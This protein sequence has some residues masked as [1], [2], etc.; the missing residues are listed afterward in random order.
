[1]SKGDCLAKQLANHIDWFKTESKSHKRLYRTLRYLVFSLT[2]ASTAL[3]GFALAQPEYQRP[4]NIA[5]I[6]VTAS[7]GLVTSIEGL[8]KPSELWIH[9]RTIY[10]SLMDLQRELQFHGSG[11]PEPGFADDVFD[12]MQIVLGSARDRWSRQIAGKTAIAPGHSGNA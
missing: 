12:R 5:I 10:Y 6:L 8:R 2:A 7:I 11:N 3:A 9:E 4:V 1:M